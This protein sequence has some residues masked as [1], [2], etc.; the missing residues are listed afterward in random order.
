MRCLG[1]GMRLLGRSYWCVAILA[2]LTAPLEGA[3]LLPYDIV[4]DSIPNSLTGAAGDA[5]AGRAAFIDRDRGHCLLCH[6]VSSIEDPFHGTIGPDLSAIGSSLTAGQLRFR[7][8]D[9]TRLSADTVMPAYYRVKGLRQVDPPFQGKPILTAQEVED[10]VA[11]LAS[12][13][14]APE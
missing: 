1:K 8:V 6:S 2:G 4:E 13:K 5:A 14:E 11:Y 7:V 9:Q 10:V 3:D 12:L